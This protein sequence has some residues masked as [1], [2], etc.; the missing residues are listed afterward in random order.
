MK[1]IYSFSLLLALL[2]LTTACDRIGGEEEHT[3][4]EGLRLM[5]GTATV[6][7]IREGV[8][9]GSISVAAG[10][11]GPQL[12]AVYLDANGNAIDVADIEE[13]STTGT[14]W[15][16][17]AIAETVPHDAWSFHVK[18]KTVGST[19]LKIDLLHNGH[20]DFTTPLIPVTVTP[21]PEKN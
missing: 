7:T 4:V 16:N 9:T 8:V 14:T 11:T 18:G 15:G 6:V 13:G 21:S 10:T 19:T 20:S 2:T 1:S 17:A 3:E 12:K 5:N